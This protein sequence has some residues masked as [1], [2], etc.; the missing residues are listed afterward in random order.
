MQPE[1]DLLMPATLQ[2]A[3]HYLAERPDV[4]PIAGGTNVLVGMREGWYDNRTLLDLNRLEEL[5]G[6]RIED[7]TV[8]IG[9]RT[10]VAELLDSPIIAEHAKPLHRAARTF[11][12]PLVRNRATVA[13]NLVD[14]S[15]AADSAPPL[16]ALNAQVELASLG[17]TRHVPLDQF[18]VGVNQTLRRPD[19]LLLSIR[20]SV[21]S[22][23]SAGAFHK[24]ALRKGT[25]CSVISAAAMVEGDGGGRCAQARIA[26]G[27]V[28]ARPIRVYAAEEGLIG[29]RLKP[30]VIEQAA[31][32]AVAAAQPIDDVR[33]TARYRKQMAG[34]LVRRLLTLIGAEL[35]RGGQ[36]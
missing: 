4:A 1:F 29:Q 19:E 23:Q 15:P 18:M 30:D 34:V 33:S 22:A 9:A 35:E 11:A 14:A 32:E 17:G 7:G 24:L 21:P 3:L 31:A 20:W 8:I 16:L 25:A 5:T 12:N 27:A 26:L 2:Q 10:T 6:I 28:A 36:E 13:G